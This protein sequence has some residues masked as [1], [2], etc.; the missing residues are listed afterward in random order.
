MTLA[1]HGRGLVRDPD[2]D[3]ELAAPESA[4]GWPGRRAARRRRQLGSD[5]RSQALPM[6]PKPVSDTRVAMGRLAIILTTAAW[7]AYVVTWFFADFFRPGH[8]GAIARSEE[9]LYS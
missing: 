4:D 7:L 6:V 3:G 9:V 2:K 1:D 5:R 8:E